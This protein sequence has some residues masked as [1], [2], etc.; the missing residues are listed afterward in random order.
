MISII[1]CSIRPD[2][3]A[4]VTANIAHTIG[5]PFE[6]KV[7]DNRGTGKGICQVYNELAATAQYSFLVFVQ[8]DVVF[9]KQGWGRELR[10]TF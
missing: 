4:Q 2:Y 6:M 7:A 3:L 1:I 8:E 5:V 9:N 10:R